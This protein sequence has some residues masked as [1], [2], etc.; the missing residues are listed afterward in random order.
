MTEKTSS[1]IVAFYTGCAEDIVIDTRKISSGEK[2]SLAD[3]QKQ[4]ASHNEEIKDWISED[5]TK[6][7]VLT[8]FERNGFLS[9][10]K[11]R[12]DDLARFAKQKQLAVP[13]IFQKYTPDIQPA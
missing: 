2:L 13:K 4:V 8:V 10:S 12:T 5:E 7:Y 3:A 11:G 1:L 6:R 9:F